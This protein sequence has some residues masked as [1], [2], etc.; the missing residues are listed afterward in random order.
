[1][2]ASAKLTD[3]Q[4]IK[5]SSY[6][7]IKVALS[8]PVEQLQCDVSADNKRRFL[9]QCALYTNPQRDTNGEGYAVYEWITR[10]ETIAEELCMS[11]AMAYRILRAAVAAG[12]IEIVDHGQR[13]GRHR[14]SRPA[15]YRAVSRAWDFGSKALA[16]TANPPPPG[17]TNPQPISDSDALEDLPF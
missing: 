5:L 12:W 6:T 17:P 15:R 4:R 3:F 8:A 11:R 10:P 1:V 2:T 14:D 9:I 16:W 13:A 7:L